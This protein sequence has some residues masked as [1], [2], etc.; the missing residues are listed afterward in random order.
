[1]LLAVMSDIH[2]NFPALSACVEDARAAGAEGFVFLGD[3]ISDL[4]YPRQTLD[5]LYEMR[6][7]WPCWFLR[8]NREDYMLRA[9]KEGRTFRKGSKEGSL[10]YTFRQLR[11]KDLEF[12]EYLPIYSRIFADGVWIEAAHAE[13]HTNAHVFEEDDP[14]LDW[15]FGDMQTG[16][17]LTGHSH[18]QYERRKDG[19]VILNPGALGIPQGRAGYAQYALADI[20]DG[21]IRTELRA[22]PYDGAAVIRAQFDSGLAGQAGMWAISILNNIV[23]GGNPMLDLLKRVEARDGAYDEDIWQQEAS[24]LGLAL[25]PEELLRRWD[26]IDRE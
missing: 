2:S 21:C 7:Q 17:L 20:S 23:S 16:L 15:V 3:Y 8:G 13:R 1:M 11:E 25:T 4:A 5:L 26:S 9:W 12:F 19:K 10:R 18:R 14:Y 22:V 6:K 24:S